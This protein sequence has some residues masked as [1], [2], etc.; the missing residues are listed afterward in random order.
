[1]QPLKTSGQA[2]LGVDHRL[3]AGLGQVDD[4]QAA[5]GQRER[6][7]ADDA[8][9]VGPRG[10]QARAIV[11]HGGDLGRPAVEAE[12]TGDAAHVWPPRSRSV[13]ERA[14]QRRIQVSFEPPPREELT[15]RL[16]GGR[17]PGERG[18]ERRRGGRRGRRTPAGRRA[19]G[20]SVVPVERRVGGEPDGLLR[21]QRRG[22]RAHL[23]PRPRRAPA[24]S[25]A[26]PTTMPCPPYPS[27]GLV[28]SW[29]RCGQDVSRCSGSAHDQV[30]TAASSA[31]S[32]K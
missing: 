31:F 15:T 29:S 21:D 12:L 6:P 4:L 24:R 25:R 2:E 9:A 20:S 23:P 27:T 13:G 22:V 14:A 30:G 17:D 19:R 26:G 28:T 8:A 7:V 11:R 10:S 1:M 18:R 3:R 32:P 5:V 16:S